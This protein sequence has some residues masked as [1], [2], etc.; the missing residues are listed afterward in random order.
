MTDNKDNVAELSCS[1]L[2]ND[3]DT[4]ITD[5]T[6]ESSGEQIADVWDDATDD[7]KTAKDKKNGK[8]SPPSRKVSTRKRRRVDA[9]DDKLAIATTDAKIDSLIV[10]LAQAEKRFD[11]KITKMTE[12]VEAV[13]SDLSTK[14]SALVDERVNARMA[15]V[16]QNLGAT[17]ADL[18]NRVKAATDE[19]QTLTTKLNNIQVAPNYETANAPNE[20]IQQLKTKVTELE[21]KLAS[22]AELITNQ[23]ELLTA[24]NNATAKKIEKIEAHSRKLNL[25]FENIPEREGENC[26]QEIERVIRQ[27]MR[28]PIRDPIDIAHRLEKTDPRKPAGIIARFRSV[29]EKSRILQNA[30]ALRG[31]NVYVRNDYPSAMVQRR[32]YLAKVVTD[33]KR[34]DPR[35][36]LVHDKLLFNGSFYTVDTV[37]SAGIPTHGHIKETDN[38]VR[39]YGYLAFLSNFHRSHVR[40]NNINFT[41]AEQAYQFIRAKARNDVTLARQIL[42]EHN[43]AVVKRLT[44]GLRRPENY[45]PSTDFEI[46]KT[47]VQA[48]FS[49]NAELKAQLLATGN[50]TLIECN[51]YDVVY[52][53]GLRIDDPQLSTGVFRGQNELGKI[54]ESVR[55]GLQ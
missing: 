26:K 50:K 6:I 25:V 34:Q 35:A 32:S 16:S 23:Q 52:S 3:A 1:E 8:Q 4:A 18:E 15:E 29:A 17:T 36:R 37:Q 22:Q 11:S 48:K 33:A 19:I 27:G 54:L 13:T 9:H 44:R 5:V 49:Q 20:E 24:S 38:Q 28:L 46:M 31:T 45:D 53:A 10:L 12:T 42:N 47:V 55:D 39:F 14:L 43:P 21:S 40:V 51:P 41:S 30:S 2:A 7:V